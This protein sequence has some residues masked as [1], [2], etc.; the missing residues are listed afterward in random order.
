M[1]TSRS[2]S[3][4]ARSPIPR[5]V[6]SPSEYPRLLA[7]ALLPDPDPHLDHH[8]PRTR[9]DRLGIHGRPAPRL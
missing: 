8:Q 4:L 9:Q 1:T 3:N 5:W 2:R 7:L 6:C